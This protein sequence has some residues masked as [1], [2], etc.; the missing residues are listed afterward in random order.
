MTPVLRLLA[1]SLLL[2]T[3][4]RGAAAPTLARRGLPL[5]FDLTPEQAERALGDAGWTVAPS[6]TT[7]GIFPGGPGQP[8]GE[9]E[10]TWVHATRDGWHANAD[11]EWSRLKR[12]DFVSAPL[13]SEAA[14]TAMVAEMRA[15]LGEPSW[16]QP[17][18]PG[19]PI[20]QWE[21]PA[22][23]VVR[24]EGQ[25]GGWKLVESWSPPTTLPPP[26]P[27]SPTPA[28]TAAPRW[29]CPHVGPPAQGSPCHYRLE[30]EACT[31]THAPTPTVACTCKPEGL[32]SCMTL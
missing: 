18:G 7:T 23:I 4:C 26:V 11:F 15:R 30:F 3:A 25:A 14:V 29:G 5:S 12:F 9:V 21:F 19:L 24:L 6:Q 1:L 22:V 17:L 2:A 16:S 28:E 13:P 31:Y 20:A 8:F 10:S 27:P 32:W